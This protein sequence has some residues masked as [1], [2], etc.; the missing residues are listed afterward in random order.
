[1]SFFGRLAAFLRRRTRIQL[2]CFNT[3][4]APPPADDRLTILVAVEGAHDV[5]FLRRISAMLHTFDARIPD[6]AA[7]ERRDVLI[8][9]PFGGGDVKLWTHRFAGLGRAEF[10]LYDRETP[11]ET[12]ARRQAADVVNA[13]PGCRAVLTTKRNL[14]NYLSPAAIHEVS[15][16]RVEFTDGDDVAELIARRSH[17]DEESEIPW[18]ELPRRARKRRCNRVKKWLNAKAVERMTPQR[19]VEQGTDDEVVG[20][21]KAIARLADGSW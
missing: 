12:E 14:E 5:E 3:A 21:L 20:W 13:R 6:L 16:I 8:F 19:L 1:M 10:H 17:A 9:V 11:P 4:F 15:R 7:M 2:S 18:S